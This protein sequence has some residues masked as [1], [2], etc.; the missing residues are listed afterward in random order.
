MRN[1]ATVGLLM[2]VLGVL[3]T[4]PVAAQ[5]GPTE[6]QRVDEAAAGRGR[7]L[8]ARYCINCHGSA[9]KGGPNGPDLI[10]SVVVLHDRL[11]SGIGPALRKSPAAHQSPLTDEQVRDL[12]HF[13][14]QRVEAIARNRNPTAPINVLTGDPEAGRAYF[15][16]AGTCSS[17]H[18]L[19]GDLAGVGRRFG[20]PVN[21]QQRMLFPSLTTS[22]R[23]QVEVTVTPESG[24][25][26]SGTLVRIDNFNVSLRDE[27]GDVRSFARVAGV[28]VDVRDPL[29]A[30]RELL[31]R[32]TDTN[33]HDLVTYLETLK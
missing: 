15:M 10:R 18:S 17:C 32:Y 7:A 28:K 20:D 30:H 22:S 4:V 27:S 13:L 31:D 16:G 33:I 26:V 29:A 21:L 3:T 19:S 11:G 1:S 9:A 8:Y 2:A 14:H 6:R 24:P 5:G 23:K 12:S 25:A